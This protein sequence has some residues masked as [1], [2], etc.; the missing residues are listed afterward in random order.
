M[1]VENL[2]YCTPLRR[3]GK[4]TGI[5]KNMTDQESNIFDSAA[6]REDF[7]KRSR[8]NLQV[9]ALNDD[10][11][12]QELQEQHPDVMRKMVELAGILPPDEKVRTRRIALKLLHQITTQGEIE[13]LEARFW[14]PSGDAGDAD[15]PL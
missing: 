7:L 15:R 10:E 4:E 1:L 6:E 12:E 8:D 2:F 11:I 3:F 5:I 14:S 13:R 9:D